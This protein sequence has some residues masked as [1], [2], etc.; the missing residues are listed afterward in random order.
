MNSCITDKRIGAP[1]FDFADDAAE[2]EGQFGVEL[3]RELLHAAVLGQAGHV[4]QTKAAVARGEQRAA[5]QR[6]ADAVA[7]PR[8][9]DAD[10]GFRLAG[11]A[12]AELPQLRGAAHHAVDE[13]AVHDGVERKRQIHEIADEV[14]GYAAAE[15]AVPARRVEPQQMVAVFIV[16][17]RSTICG[18]RRHR[19][20]LSCI[21]EVS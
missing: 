7:L 9:L 21:P 5:Q 13:K 14:V 18:S 10:R 20:E 6:R 19:E 1:G 2:V 3:A 15:P 11:K 12:H 17:R 4:Q 8:L 16:S